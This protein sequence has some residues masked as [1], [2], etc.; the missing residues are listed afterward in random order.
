MK[1]TLLTLIAVLFSFFLIAQN[2]I[3]IEKELELLKERQSL[4]LE[5]TEKDI[6]RMYVMFS[7]IGAYFTIFSLV[8]GIRQFNID[9]NKNRHEEQYM[10]EM[11]SMMNSFKDNI[12]VVNSLIDSL[13]TTFDFKN[14]I[15]ISV[16]EIDSRINQLNT[17]KE[18][19]ELS[20]KS[21]IEKLNRRAI[22]LYEKCQIHKN[23]RD[24]FKNEENRIPL[25]SF[26]SDMNTLE[27]TGDIKQLASPI[28]Y[29]I[30][31]LSKF[32][33]MEYVDSVDDI[34]NSRKMA[35]EQIDNPLGQYGEW[36]TDL[37]KTNLKILINEASY[38]LAIMYYN[39]GNIDNSFDEFTK[40]YETNN[41]DFRSRVYIPELM[42]FDNNCD[43]NKVKTEFYSVETELK[44]VTSE[45]RKKIAW[46]KQYGILKMKE[47]NFYIEKPKILRIGNR[48][49]IFNEYVNNEKAIECFWDAL[50]KISNNSFVKFSLAQTMEYIGQ[51]SLWRDRKPK[52]LFTE[53]FYQFRNEIIIK[54]EP[55]LLCLMN[56]IIGICAHYAKISGETP[57]LYLLQARQHLQKVPKNIKIFSPINK[58]MLT[59][60][61]LLNEINEFD[62][63][64]KI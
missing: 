52:E 35:N 12:G 50:E 34:S 63:I 29:F 54:T 40:C 46:D 22:K 37:I 64:C 5:K 32:N 25:I 19:E 58:I 18:K 59:H 24:D 43:P 56:Y 55:I 61:Q 30:R 33:T 26:S 47:G 1:K 39:L 62:K 20:F 48:N 15:A 3:N 13:K 31:G 10:N 57:N 11:R 7:I 53:V 6:N 21:E 38:H 9:K 36:N 8:L 49:P 44:N 28:S 51:S 16:K 45:N 27:K 17:F 2:D 41:L 4:I 42:F 23:N 60:E 14:E